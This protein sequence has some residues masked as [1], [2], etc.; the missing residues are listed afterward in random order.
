MKTTT[1]FVLQ[2]FKWKDTNIFD[3][4]M[5]D[6]IFQTR[7]TIYRDFLTD[8][9]SPNTNTCSLRGNNP[10]DYLCLYIKYMIARKTSTKNDC[11]YQLLL[12]K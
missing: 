7:L 10:Q 12:V 1:I 9:F 4:I 3:K 11:D 5:I 8:A 2:V 6:F